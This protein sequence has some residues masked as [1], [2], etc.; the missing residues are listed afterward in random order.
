M[1]TLTN[2]AT[3]SSPERHTRT[4]MVYIFYVKEY[5]NTV[6]LQIWRVVVNKWL[7][8]SH[9]YCF[10]FPWLVRC[11][12]MKKEGDGNK[13]HG[14]QIRMKASLCDNV[15]FC[16]AKWSRKGNRLGRHV[17][18][19]RPRTRV[20]MRQVM[21]SIRIGREKTGIREKQNKRDKHSIRAFPYYKW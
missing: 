20:G 14:L 6:I 19:R 10:L 1:T 21:L 11:V 18:E 17:H 8:L 5:W 15:C 2:V 7:L 4:K 16:F 9:C 3:N 13:G 12:Q